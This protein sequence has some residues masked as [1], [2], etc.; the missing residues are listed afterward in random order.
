MADDTGNQ[1]ELL[2]QFVDLTGASPAEV[3]IAPIF[4][5][6]DGTRLTACRRNNISR[7]TDGISL[8]QLL[9]FTR[10]KKKA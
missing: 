9:S 8:A 5:K 2:S 4:I 1:D 3:T 6:H 7:P 10:L